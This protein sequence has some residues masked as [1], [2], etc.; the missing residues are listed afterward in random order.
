MTWQPR[1]VGM[2]DN[3]LLPSNALLCHRAIAGWYLSQ[4]GAPTELPGSQLVAAYLCRHQGIRYAVV[5]TTDCG[6]I[7]GGVQVLSVYHVRSNE[8]LVRIDCWPQE[9]ESY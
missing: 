1:S 8:A 3:R 9:I 4:P 5:T 6:S 2:G 7:S